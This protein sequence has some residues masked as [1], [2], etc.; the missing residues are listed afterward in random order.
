VDEDLERLKQLWFANIL[1]AR[2]G[3]TDRR[4]TERI[5][6]MPVVLLF[7]FRFVRLL[8]SGHQAVAIEN[9]ALRMQIAAFQRKRKRPLL[10]TWDR[11]FW[12]TLRSVWSGWRH[13]LMY[14]QADTVVRWHREHFRRCWA[15]LSKT[16]RRRRG[17]PGTA[18]ELRRLI[19]RIAAANPLWRA[20]RI[21]GELK[22]IGIAT[23]ERNVS[24][25]LRRLRRPPNQTWRTFLHNH[26][27]QLVSI[28]FFT[29]PTITMRVLFVLIVLEH[30]R[31][32]VLHF[33]V[34]EHPTGA[35]TAQQI[36][37]AFAD[38]EAAQYL[39]RDHDSRYGAEVRL[40]IQSLG[41]QEI[42]TAPQS[43]WQN[44]YAERLIGSI[45]RECLNHYVILNARHLK[46][47]LSSYFRYYHQSRTHLSLDKQ[48]PFPREA[49]KVGK[50]LAIPQLGG[51]HHRYE[52]IAA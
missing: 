13:P 7:V 1:S 23:S 28:D 31:R 2:A 26:I 18:A 8:F 17:R 48:C 46:R 24:R 50:I 52:R 21:H 9:A 3:L 6:D 44:P 35:W 29:V 51:L 22:M 16:Q 41:I 15:R 25:I 32:K 19:E 49:L 5:G 34:T 27:G 45:R 36:V 43:P 47:T 37:E 11:V 40:R 20:P 30:D 42:L 10:T 12:I 38:R 33:N 4:W 39:I 14:V